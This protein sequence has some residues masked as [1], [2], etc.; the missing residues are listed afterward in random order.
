MKQ[1]PELDRVQQRMQPGEL[2]LHGFLGTDT[3]L[4]VDIL[5]ADQWVVQSHGVTHA[6]IADRL[7]ALTEKGRDLAER[8][9][10]VEGRYRVCVRDDRGLIPSPWGDGMF[11]KGEARLVDDRTDRSFRWSGL[12]LHLIRTHGFYSGRGSVYRIDPAD[13]IAVLGLAREDNQD[14]SSNG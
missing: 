1:T 6:Q 4:L 5:A 14:L 2:T 13:A 9:V 3:R 12:S 8:E 11:E 7:A 10:L